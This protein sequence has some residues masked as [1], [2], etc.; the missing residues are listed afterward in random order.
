H[1][2]ENPSASLDDVLRLVP[3]PDFGTLSR[4][5]S[6]AIRELYETGRAT[7]RLRTV[8]E[9][10]LPS[11]VIVTVP[12]PDAAPGIESFFELVA[13]AV[14]ASRLE[15]LERARFRGPTLEFDVTRGM[16]LPTFRQKL[17]ELVPREREVR[18]RLPMPLV[19]WLRSFLD[20]RRKQGASD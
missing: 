7:L 13:D 14:K 18:Y 1:L 19:P 12:D 6:A 16:E 8:F 20:E 2:L 9:L 11:T 3:G 17:E 4:G 5:D 15:G 10:K